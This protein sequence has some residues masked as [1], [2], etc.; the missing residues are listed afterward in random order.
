MA[1]HHFFH[2]R[3]IGSA[4]GK[5]RRLSR[6][7]RIVENVQ[8]FRIEDAGVQTTV[9]HVSTGDFGRLWAGCTSEA[10]WLTP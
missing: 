5:Q 3:D 8:S 7:W 10:I 4:L 1:Q 2:S 6:P 9:P